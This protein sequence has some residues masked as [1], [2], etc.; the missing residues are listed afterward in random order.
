MEKV[1]QMCLI[2]FVRRLF[3]KK[4]K[5][6]P[7]LKERNKISKVKT[8]GL[9]SVIHILLTGDSAKLMIPLQKHVKPK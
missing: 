9:A 1:I 8:A 7:L 5:Q 6:C 3:G 4:K 2:I